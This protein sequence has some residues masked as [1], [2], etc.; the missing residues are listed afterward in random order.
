M[1][2]EGDL[3]GAIGTAR[4]SGSGAGFKRKREKNHE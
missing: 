1:C 2:K 3:Q 4:R